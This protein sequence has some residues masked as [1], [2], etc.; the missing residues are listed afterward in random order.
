MNRFKLPLLGIVALA[1]LTAGNGR[2]ALAQPQDQ[3][4]VQPPCVQLCGGFEGFTVVVVPDTQCYTSS[5]A[6]ENRGSCGAA[7][8]ANDRMMQTGAGWIVANRQFLNITAVL[9]VGD[10]TECGSS[11]DNTCGLAS[12]LRPRLEPTGLP[13]E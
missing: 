3:Q 4:P 6:P 8:A 11:D 2:S 13:V 10:T 9:S 7:P 1:A 12:G 5:G